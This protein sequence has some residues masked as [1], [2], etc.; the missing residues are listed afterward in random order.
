ML[1]AGTFLVYLPVW[2][3]GFIW[4][5]AEF[6][7]DNPL[8]RMPDG[9]YRFWF[10][11]AAPD[12]FPVTSTMLWL[13][14][15]LWG[16]HP[17]GYHLVNVLLHA[18][19]SVLLW[20]VLRRLN[21]RG[22]AL[23]AAIF[24]VHPVNV[25]SVAWITERKNTLSMLLYLL[26][27]LLF[28]RFERARDQR[29][30]AAGPKLD[31]RPLPPS[32][33][34]P[35]SSVLYALSLLAFAF[36]LLS[37]T[38]VVPLPLVLLGIAWWRQ[39]RVRLRDLWTFV[40]F[41]ALAAMAAVVTVWFQYHRAIGASMLDV[42][43]DSFWSRLAGAGW[44]VWFYAY[45]ALLPMNLSFVYPRWQI[46]PHQLLSYSPGLLVV[47]L[48]L[49]S[50]HYRRR[51][52]KALL[53]GLGYFVLLLLPVLGFL[54][55][56]FM[57]YSLVADHWQY[58]A[59]IGPIALLAAGITTAFGRS[60]PVE[61][62]AR[63]SPSPAPL[64]SRWH[65]GRLS[66]LLQGTLCGALLLA[67]GLL[68]WRQ[69]RMYTDLETLWVTTLARN[70]RASMAH[71]NLGT[72]LLARGQVTEALAHF[73]AALALQP[74][75]ADV[76]SNLGSALLSLR[77]LDEAVTHFRDALRIQPDSALAHNN[78]GTALLQQGH[79][80][81]AITHLT[82]TVELQ[83]S[84]ASTHHNLAGALLQAGRWDEAAA[85]SQTALELQPAFADAE[86]TLGNT[87]LHQGHVAEALAHLQK[88][89]ELEPQSPD[90]QHNLASAF[91][92]TGQVNE[93]VLHFQKAL[94]LR[95]GFARAHNSLGNALLREGR[96]DEAISHFQT[97]VRLQP[98][99]AEAHLNLADALLQ[100]GQLDEA[101]AHF[102]VGLELQ[103]NLA[104]AHNNFANALLR[105]GRVDEAITHFLSALSLQPNLPE[106]HYNL[107]GALLLKARPAEAL[108]HYEAAASAL[109]GNPYLLNNLA[110]LLATCSDPSVRNGPRAVDLALRAEQLA[111][112]KDPSF[113]GTLAAAYAE[114][115]RFPEAIAAAERACA[116]ASAAGNDSLL[117]K[118]QE[119]LQLY[120]RSQ[121][122]HE[123]APAALSQK[124]HQP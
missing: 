111:G 64:A 57:R 70:P 71:N 88:A 54:N 19:S 39:G 44:A 86:V 47:T 72:L 100:S 13:E 106:A 67:L 99:L 94:A 56:Y 104:G 93:A 91:L 31:P 27:M 117:K 7:V 114:A 55:I 116:G 8:I 58:F 96:F 103:P 32:I 62:S 84:L 120:R 6:L 85:Q 37:K 53:F 4:D 20:R 40:P 14:W 61:S 78:L 17:L 5:D 101:I 2:H 90:A 124:S 29:K 69:A 59:I 110:W 66:A 24:A 46:D 107:A 80:D 87:L 18:L 38:A 89:I 43:N 51:W 95:P 98:S 83:P 28:L 45:K 49:V 22:A 122:Y 65:L 92:Q 77:R 97:A 115:G 3:A 118:N 123:P 25:E 68:A 34:Q 50:W 11:S 35:P 42:R 102:Q 30:Q 79:L 15:R 36:A 73:Q 12:Y 75:A 60:H 41:F 21:I 105:Q 74:N 108:T 33:F 112:G 9:L 82:K 16:A 81:E 48:F 23:A 113:L 10:T 76:H 26:S 109:P 121:P 119:F 1:L 52:G 63:H